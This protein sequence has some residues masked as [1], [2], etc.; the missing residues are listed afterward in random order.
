MMV[1]RHKRQ[2]TVF[3]I[4]SFIFLLS[5][6]L[7]L[8]QNLYLVLIQLNWNTM[9]WKI[10]RWNDEKQIMLKIKFY[11]WED[12]ANKNTLICYPF[13]FILRQM[14]LC[15]FIWCIYWLVCLCFVY[16]WYLFW[17]SS[18][19]LYCIR[20][21]HNIFSHKR[22]SGISK[23]KQ[24][25]SYLICKKLTTSLSF[26]NWTKIVRKISTVWLWDRKTIWS[27]VSRVRARVKISRLPAVGAGAGDTHTSD[28]EP[29]PSEGLLD[30]ALIIS[31]CWG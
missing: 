4:E 12:S 23:L 20:V 1:P 28:T 8:E 3:G 30:S 29:E 16:Y 17:N 26:I 19:V 25:W 18:V 9:I 27:S 5:D 11:L 21:E 10:K 6:R 14:L 31:L 22:N 2:Q 15:N 7:V 13:N 24:F